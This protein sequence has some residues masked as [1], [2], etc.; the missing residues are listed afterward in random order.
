[1]Q[2]VFSR[3][4]EINVFDSFLWVLSDGWCP[5]PTESSFLKSHCFGDYGLTLHH[6]NQSNPWD[7]F[8]GLPVNPYPAVGYL[9]HFLFELIGNITNN[10]NIGQF[11]YILALTLSSFFPCV[12]ILKSSI[13]NKVMKVLILSPLAGTLLFAIDRGNAVVFTI[14]FIF[15]AFKSY[16]EDNLNKLLLFIVI[17]S[18]LKPVFI[19]L[20]CIF[21][22]YKSY[23]KALLGL[24]LVSVVHFI[25]FI[26]FTDKNSIWFILKKYL[27]SL[28]YYSNYQ[29][30][31]NIYPYNISFTRGLVAW[32]NV[33]TDL[34]QLESKSFLDFIILHKNL[35]S[36]IPLILI[37]LLFYF[38]G[39]KLVVNKLG[40][41]TFLLT[42]CISLSP[43]T[44]QYYLVV[45]IPILAHIFLLKYSKENEIEKTFLDIIL[46]F[47]TVLMI[48]FSVIPVIWLKF[49]LNDINN[50]LTTIFFVPFLIALYLILFIIQTFRNSY[51]AYDFDE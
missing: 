35:I 20:L 12:Y 28:K 34:S 15:L 49:Y 48:A 21:I 36:L 40:L 39:S 8:S 38:F 44:Y 23:S 50:Y 25:S 43:I 22:L 27:E 10:S 4:L 29:S 3:Y 14:P 17:L 6:F 41:F 9:T 5:P 16:L 7:E 46:H 2:I 24:G 30:L 18:I 37:S 31:E 26:Q 47:T 13:H 42:V 51:F 11:L 45:Y 33:I 1:M 32:S 19:I